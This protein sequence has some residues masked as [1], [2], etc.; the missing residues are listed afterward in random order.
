MASKLLVAFAYVLILLQ[1]T[2]LGQAPGTEQVYCASLNTGSTFEAVYSLYQSYGACR[3]TCVSKYAFGVV[4]GR[5]CWCSDAAPGDTTDVK[6]CN[7]NCPGY[8][9]DKCGSTNNKLFG[10]IQLDKKPST[11]IGGSTTTTSSVSTSGSLGPSTDTT[12]TPAP[13]PTATFSSSLIFR[14][15]VYSLSTFFSL[16]RGV[17]TLSEDPDSSSLDIPWTFLT[18]ATTQTGPSTPPSS[19]PAPVTITVVD[20]QTRSGTTTLSTEKSPSPSSA[21]DSTTSSAASSSSSSTST[22][23]VT[24]QTLPGATVTI[25]NNNLPS[26]TAQP[27]TGNKG[28]SGGAT[29]GIVIGSLALVALIGLILFFW[30]CYR[31]KSSDSQKEEADEYLNPYYER[32]VP[33]PVFRP[34]HG[35]G[36]N[37]TGPTL[38]IPSSN[39][40]RLKNGIY[41]NGS[42][43]SNV[44]LQDNQDYS[45]PVRPALRLTNPDPPEN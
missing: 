37:R 4:Q 38:T 45:R 17:P 30:F 34:P 3:D 36:P 8:P 7:E 18:T 42:R 25:P 15:P 35:S 12:P 22:P 28:L 29:A 19:P 1:T 27:S 31:R 43:R 13:L 2:V 40:S 44:S 16:S 24:T 41:P 39:D 20:S 23:N 14:P 10:Y 5:Y 33:Q 6:S 21:T 11:T 26:Q 32:A 9:K